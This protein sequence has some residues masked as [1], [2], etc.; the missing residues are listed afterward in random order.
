MTLRAMVF[1]RYEGAF[2]LG[3]V[4]WAFEYRTGW[5][6]AGSVENVHGLPEATPKDMD[7]WT[8]D[9]LDPVSAMAQWHYDA[10]KVLPVEHPAP[11]AARRVIAWIGQQPYIFLQR[12]CV[13]DAYDVLRAY[14]LIDLALPSKTLIP[15]LW[16]AALPGPAHQLDGDPALIQNGLRHVWRVLPFAHERTLHIATNISVPPPPWRAEGNAAQ[17]FLQAALDE[18]KLKAENEIP[19]S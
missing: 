18:L 11:R 19:T 8:K 6:N 16:F 9:T 15:N 12:N 2:H 14:G 5:F 10:Y 3:H 7:F 4:G 1:V 13:D 17:R